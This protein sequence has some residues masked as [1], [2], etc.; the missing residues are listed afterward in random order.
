MAEKEIHGPLSFSCQPSSCPTERGQM[1][2]R[3]P[4]PRK[5]DISQ[6]GAG[7]AVNRPV[8]KP[9]GTSVLREA[10]VTLTFLNNEHAARNQTLWS[11]SPWVTRHAHRSDP[12]RAEKWMPRPNWATH[13]VAP[14]GH[15]SELVGHA[16]SWEAAAIAYAEGTAS[17][18]E[19]ASRTQLCPS[20][21]KKRTG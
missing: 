13:G 7:P 3:S 18:W 1:A 6:V 16:S 8:N 11:E 19:Q 17:F 20:T 14:S 12:W 5:A 10:L 2:F 9:P 4:S 21:G 15:Q